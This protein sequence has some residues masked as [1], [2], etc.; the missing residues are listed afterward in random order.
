MLTWRRNWLHT[1]YAV[2]LRCRRRDHYLK[3][4]WRRSR[5][6]AMALFS[7]ISVLQ[8]RI[9][10]LWNRGETSRRET[11]RRR[12]RDRDIKSVVG[13]RNR[14]EMSPPQPTMRVWRRRKLLIGVRVGTAAENVFWCILS[15][16]EPTW[17]QKLVFW[18]FL[19]HKNCLN[20]KSHALKLWF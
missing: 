6:L 7:H 18:H 12:W 15:L 9:Q 16:K 11:R 1:L 3:W 8:G 10:D 4:P 13:K 2:F 17:W 5:S 14:H 19:T 20:V